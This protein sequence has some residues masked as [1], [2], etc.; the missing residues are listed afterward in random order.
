[1][2]VLLHGAKKNAGDYLIFERAQELIRA[3]RK[4]E[5]FLILSRWMTVVER[6]R[7]TNFVDFK[8][9]TSRMKLKVAHNIIRGLIES[10]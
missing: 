2:Y 9:I 4:T 6:Y 1:M 3:Y 7:Q 10:F 8:A 5:D